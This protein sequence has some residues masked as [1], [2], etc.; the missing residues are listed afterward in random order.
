MNNLN[1]LND[2]LCIQMFDE[3]HEDFSRDNEIYQK[4]SSKWLAELRIPIFTLFASKRV[5]SLN[6]NVL[7]LFSKLIFYRLKAPL[8]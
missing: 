3:H 8:K 2:S 1:K 7:Y 4:I 6:L 5:Y